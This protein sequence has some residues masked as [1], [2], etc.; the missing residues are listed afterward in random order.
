MLPL[1]FHLL[2]QPQIEIGEKALSGFISAK[3]QALLIYLALSPGRQ[4]RT[5]LANLLWSEFSDDQAR[6]NLRTTLSN[7]NGLVSPHLTIE[8][9]AVG[10]NRNQPHWLD[11]D[12]VRT[13]FES[14][15]EGKDLHQLAETSALYRGGL[16]EG[17]SIRNTPIFEDWLLMQREHYHGMVLR[18]LSRLAD[19]CIAEGAYAIG[20]TTTRRL[21]LLEPW[22]EQSHR[23]QMLLLAYDGQRSAALTQYETCRAVMAAEFGVQPQEETTALSQQVRNG[24]L[25][26]P[27]PRKLAGPGWIG[28]LRQLVQP[29]F[30]PASQPSPAPLQPSID[31]DSLPT[32]PQ[33]VGREA[34]ADQLTAWLTK[35]Q[36]HL[37][38]LHGLRGQGKSALAA[39]VV[40]SLVGPSPL[41]DQ[42]LENPKPEAG[43]TEEKPFQ[44]VFWLSL[45]H[46]PSLTEMLRT[47]VLFFAKRDADIP[48]GVD[49]MISLLIEC[50]RRWRC[51]L[52]LDN[53]EDILSK[54]DMTV[55][56]AQ[57]YREYSNFFKRI[58][59]SDHQS[60]LLLI[61]D[62]QFQE[63]EQLMQSAGPRVREM[64]LSPLTRQASRLLLR[65]QG[66]DAE[67][68]LLDCAAQR[69]ADHPLALLEK[70]HVV[71][72]LFS[73]DL[74]A[75]LDAN[76]PITG[77]IYDLLAES[78]ARLS[79]LAQ[80]ILSLL[81]EART[82]LGWSDF[83][84]SLS[85][86]HSTRELMEA[87]LLLL[88]R[89]LV[90]KEGTGIGLSALVAGY[91]KEKGMGRAANSI[92]G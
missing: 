5:R 50:L 25:P 7:L 8:R 55:G 89:C 66:I 82:P 79:P 86:T 56:A 90:E 81:A 13:T 27:T 58:A 54:A 62:E 28:R 3:A 63:M 70:A 84:G 91:M 12:V 45:R 31:W 22:R 43:P 15:L 32:A 18:G 53:V 26:L 35:E 40:R 73:G 20:L 48:S 65:R 57:G 17:F 78:F 71:N 92:S 88:R 38:T 6:N 46:S 33:L 44:V 76:I 77:A 87:Q 14:S 51:L 4:S 85:S 41:P 61:S 47:W 34:E 1:R 80:E 69:C 36:C 52:V 2:G 42:F 37:V 83:S 49:E 59:T 60:C 16:L 9:D 67:D 72:A 75:Y 11:V 10:Y 68:G 23:Q 19:R 64:R 74:A 29:A 24:T 30:A 39:S 21:L